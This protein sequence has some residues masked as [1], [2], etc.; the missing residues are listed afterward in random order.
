MRHECRGDLCG[1]C[2]RRIEQ[3]EDRRERRERYNERD[4]DWAAEAAARDMIFGREL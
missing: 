2:E 4:L 3:E 1:I